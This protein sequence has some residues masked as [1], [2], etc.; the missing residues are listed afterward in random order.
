MTVI[1]LVPKVESGVPSVL[2]R[3]TTM[4]A[5]V[6][7][8]VPTVMIL[9]STGCRTTAKA[10]SSWDVFTSVVTRPVPP[11]TLA[12]SGVPFALYRAS[13]TAVDGRE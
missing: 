5:G 3:I 9:P 13:A 4:L 12:V 1:P 11:T 7:K 2:Y 10:T 6:V 8:L